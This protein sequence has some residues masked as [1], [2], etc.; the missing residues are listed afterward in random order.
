MGHLYTALIAD[1]AVRFQLLLKEDASPLFSTGTDEHGSKIQKAAESSNTSPGEYC[2]EISKRYQSLFDS[3]GIKYT[4][5]IR[6]SDAAHKE[7][8]QHFW[9]SSLIPFEIYTTEPVSNQL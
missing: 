5:F 1:A 7:A 6:T 3:C 9:V 8:V 2:S 4:H